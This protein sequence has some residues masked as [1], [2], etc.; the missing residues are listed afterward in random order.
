MNHN[1]RC[2]PFFLYTRTEEV[3]LLCL[4]YFVNR[5]TDRI[6][7]TSFFFSNDDDDDSVDDHDNYF[8]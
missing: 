4:V 6:S 7:H 1:K 8:I 2:L 5:V 3:N